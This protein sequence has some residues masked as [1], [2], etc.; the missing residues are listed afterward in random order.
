VADRRPRKRTRRPPRRRLRRLTVKH[1]ALGVLALVAF[2]YY[3]PLTTY[4]HTRAE[5]RE[6]TAEV[7]ALRVRHQAL[8]GKFA[9]T[10][11][12]LALAREARQLSFVRKGERLYVVTG[13]ERWRRGFAHHGK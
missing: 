8:R 12:A 6:R 11:S 9:P 4:F 13:L 1:V 3:R 5:V 2:L 7:Q 10:S